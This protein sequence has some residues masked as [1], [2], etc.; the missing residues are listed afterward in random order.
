VFPAGPREE[1]DGVQVITFSKEQQAGFGI[2]KYGEITDFSQWSH[3]DDELKHTARAPWW[4]SMHLRPGMVYPNNWQDPSCFETARDYDWM[5]GTERSCEKTVEDCQQR[6]V[7]VANCAHFNFYMNCGCRL[8]DNSSSR[9]L[10]K[11]A[12]N[13]PP[14]C[15][16]QFSKKQQ[17]QFG[18]DAHGSV[19]NM[20]I[21][22]TTF[23]RFITKSVGMQVERPWWV[24]QK[25]HPAGQDLHYPGWTATTFSMEQ[26]KQFSIDQFGVVLDRK[27]FEDA[28]NGRA[29]LGTDVDSLWWIQNGVFPDGPT[30]RIQPGGWVA[31]SFSKEQQK[32]F[33]IDDQ[34]TIIQR[35]TFDKAISQLQGIKSALF[36]FDIV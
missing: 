9:H 11:T 28:I 10:S 20:I 17:K 7:S 18:I 36:S 26:Q 8:S 6:C 3:A 13:G 25:V 33:G 31:S 1:L 27:K 22:N 30:E 35:D 15:Q 34:G 23:G 4:I 19:K 16:L 5:K 29:W 32:H 24:T 2:N 21:W 14:I 12:T